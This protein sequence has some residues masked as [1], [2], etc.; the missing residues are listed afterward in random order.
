MRRVARSIVQWILARCARHYHSRTGMRI[1][2]VLGSTRGIFKQYL[3]RS[4]TEHVRANPNGYT[5]AL[6][7][8]LSI[9]DI[10]AGCSSSSKWLHIICVAV[11]RAL[12]ATPKYMTLVQEVSV[13]TKAEALRVLDIAI[14]DVCI[15]TE[16]P[17]ASAQEDAYMT[18]I[19]A[20]KPRGVVYLP[21]KPQQTI[22]AHIMQFGQGSEN[23]LMV[24]H[25]Q[26]HEDGTTFEW[27]AGGNRHRDQVRAFGSH[28][29]YARAISAHMFSP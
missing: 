5:Y 9:L 7:I 1:I 15:C 21:W 16:K 11:F 2:F 3:L 22:S 6:G 23:S 27:I 4:A 19:G 13:N 26:E 28:H 20:M 18:I 10:E 24:R 29:V 14:P 8:P 25:E 12:K 17:L